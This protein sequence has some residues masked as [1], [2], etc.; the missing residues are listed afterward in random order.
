MAKRPTKTKTAPDNAQAVAT[1]ADLVADPH[2]PRTI[3]DQA[4]A[5]LGY[6]LAEFGDLGGIVFNTRT[7]QLVAGHQRV[8]QLREQ[9]GDLAVD[10]DT[11]TTP[12]GHAFRLRLVD[13]PLAKQRAAN[14]AANSP[15]VAGQF[16][17]DLA[18]YA[19]SV[20]EAE[21]AAFESLL[22]ADLL[23]PPT[24]DSPDDPAPRAA[25]GGSAGRLEVVIACGDAPEAKRVAAKVRKAGLTCR[26]RGADDDD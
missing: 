25:G 7:R 14:L 19:L 15:T 12:A 9:Y 10:G 26:I 2:N 21:P 13:W 4:A 1:L 20:A 5:G 11:L 3:T 23:G 6:S 16:N 18:T 24:A 22:L 8:A 17:E